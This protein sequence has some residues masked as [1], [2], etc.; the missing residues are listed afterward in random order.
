MIPQ[1]IYAEERK[2]RQGKALLQIIKKVK[3]CVNTNMYI[4]HVLKT[5]VPVD[6]TNNWGLTDPTPRLN[7]APQLA[8]LS[9]EY[10]PHTLLIDVDGY[11]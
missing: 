3:T 9:T 7:A 5:N 8:P 10:A 4:T 2:K 11:T 6:S 1:V